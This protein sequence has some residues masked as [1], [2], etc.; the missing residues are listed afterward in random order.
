MKVFGAIL[1][2][3]ACVAWGTV[4]NGVVAAATF[5]T[6]IFSVVQALAAKA[7]ASAAKISAESL[8]N[9]E[10]AW[11]TVKRVS[12][13]VMGMPNTST[14][15]RGVSTKRAFV[16]FTGFRSRIPAGSKNL[17][18]S[19]TLFP[20]LTFAQHRSSAAR[21]QIAHWRIGFFLW[22][23]RPGLLRSTVSAP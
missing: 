3:L 6:A 21:I 14:P 16:R 9:S 7:N 13:Y 11:L 10:R 18:F 19:L 15:W 23:S 20:Q 2:V 22:Q 5:A 1:P 17:G 12:L 4:I 8:I